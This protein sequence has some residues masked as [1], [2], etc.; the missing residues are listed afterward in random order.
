MITQSLQK[1]IND[2]IVIAKAN[3]ERATEAMHAGHNIITQRWDSMHVIEVCEHCEC[4]ASNI[5]RK[6]T[7]KIVKNVFTGAFAR[8]DDGK[9][10]KVVR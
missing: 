5:I 4:T 3:N 6:P 9:N 7:N 10:Y 1:A 2:Q 8:Q